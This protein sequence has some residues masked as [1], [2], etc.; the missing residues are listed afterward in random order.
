MYMNNLLK[1]QKIYNAIE[2]SNIYTALI[3]HPYRS[4][5]NVCFTLPN[6]YLENLFIEQANKE[7]LF[8]LRGH[9]KIGGIRVSTYNAMPMAGV[10]KLVNFMQKFAIAN[11]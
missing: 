11:A 8:M 7:Q 5:L 10:T 9:T 2:N 6:K 4:F 1:S 3:N